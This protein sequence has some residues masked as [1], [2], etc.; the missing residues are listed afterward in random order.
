MSIIKESALVAI[1]GCVIVMVM[2]GA[3]ALLTRRKVR[4]T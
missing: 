3:G 4:L 2:V 1:N